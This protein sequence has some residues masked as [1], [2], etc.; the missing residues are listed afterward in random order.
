MV[1][2]STSREMIDAPSASGVGAADF[3]GEVASIRQGY[4]VGGLKVFERLA[5][6]GS[7]AFAPSFDLSNTE[8]DVTVIEAIETTDQQP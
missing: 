4:E 2:L 1:H 7:G 3:G 6:G 5:S 8:R